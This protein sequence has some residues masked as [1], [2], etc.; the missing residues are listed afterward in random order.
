MY[1][2]REANLFCPCVAKQYRGSPRSGKG[3]KNF[4][5]PKPEG[6]EDNFVILNKVSNFSHP[7]V[8]KATA[9]LGQRSKNVPLCV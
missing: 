9:P 3:L 8:A 6:L 1:G 4:S 7:S 2:K 5:T